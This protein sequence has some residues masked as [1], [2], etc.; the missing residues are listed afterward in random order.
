MLLD[1]ENDQ[2]FLNE[3]QD[4]SQEE[5]AIRRRGERQWR[6]GIRVLHHENKLPINQPGSQPQYIEAER[7][8]IA[9]FGDRDKYYKYTHHLGVVIDDQVLDNIRYRDLVT[10]AQGTVTEW[11]IQKALES[12][13]LKGQFIRAL[14]K[15]MERNNIFIPEHTSI[16]RVIESFKYERVDFSES[17]YDVTTT[18]R[19]TYEIFQMRFNK[20]S[21][22]SVDSEPTIV[23]YAICQ[24]CQDYMPVEAR[25]VNIMNCGFRRRRDYKK[26]QS[27]G[28]RAECF[29][30]KDIIPEISKIVLKFNLDR[31]LLNH[32]AEYAF[33]EVDHRCVSERYR[34]Y[35]KVQMSAEA[36]TESKMRVYKNIEVLIESEYENNNPEF[37]WEIFKNLSY[38]V[39]YTP[40][41]IIRSVTKWADNILATDNQGLS[42][43]ELLSIDWARGE[44]QREFG[45]DNE[46]ED[47][48][49]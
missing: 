4:L 30:L 12:N 34:S 21:G 25:C 44:F 9:D 49:E 20:F 16:D 15:A 28:P 35:A 37:S 3:I 2:D 13:V 42:P 17:I 47:D 5:R 39:M 48:E 6:D 24:G 1:I 31:K 7:L 38:T 22:F 45:E 18:A 23:E 40:P 32:I 41:E 10:L 33:P 11:S 19:D 27:I 36:Y 14:L 8:G 43:M 46:E 26:C 29:I